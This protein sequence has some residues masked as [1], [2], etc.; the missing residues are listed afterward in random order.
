MEMRYIYKLP[1]SP[2]LITKGLWGSL[3]ILSGLGPDDPGSN[4][5]ADKI[6]GSES[7]GSPILMRKRQER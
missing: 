7:P 3:A 6:A 5:S 1:I 4:D 2:N